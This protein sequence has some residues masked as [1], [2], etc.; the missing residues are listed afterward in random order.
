MPR[1]DPKKSKNMRQAQ[2][3]MFASQE[4]IPIQSWRSILLEYSDILSD[5]V[6]KEDGAFQLD[7]EKLRNSEQV[8]ESDIDTLRNIVNNEMITT[9]YLN[10]LEKL[11][12]NELHFFMSKIEAYSNSNELK[13][14]INN[15]DREL[16]NINP[17]KSKYNIESD[18]YKF[19]DS[20]G[21][22]DIFLIEI[23][24]EKYIARFNHNEKI[25]EDKFASDSGMDA[26]IK[27]YYKSRNIDQIPDLKAY[28]F[29]K[30]VLILEYI[31]GDNFKESNF[32]GDTKLSREEIEEL[33]N[34]ILE[35]HNQELSLDLRK[36]N[37]IYSKDSGIHPIDVNLKRSESPKTRE[38][39]GF[40]LVYLLEL[41]TLPAKRNSDKVETILKEKLRY[42]DILNDCLNDEQFG[43]LKIGQTLVN[44]DRFM[45]KS[46]LPTEEEKMR[47]RDSDSNI[48]LEEIRKRLR[49]I[50]LIS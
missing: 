42:A 3:E 14:N 48:S 39:L 31:S 28:S 45:N 21:E 44:S 4:R 10:F 9:K 15:I 18:N 46:F 26:N 29:S 32:D 12:R 37:F 27:T 40:Q 23:D 30:E 19:L 24:G 8:D 35:I 6:I 5:S 20:G 41:I 17:N 47:L 36:K 16:N 50:G 25:A 13:Q 49:D 34:T 38:R 11:N 7:I 43:Q 2:V 33:I 1:K 22:A